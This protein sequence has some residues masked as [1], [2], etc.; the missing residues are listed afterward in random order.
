MLKITL[1][2]QAAV[3]GPNGKLKPGQ[4]VV[5][6]DSEYVRVLLK[7]GTVSLIDPPSL[8][9]DFLKEAGYEY[10]EEPVESFLTRKP[11]KKDPGPPE[12]FLN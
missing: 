2:V 3:G 10:E 6:D 8:D 4:I 1:L 5:L 7:S 9:P 12:P 11:P